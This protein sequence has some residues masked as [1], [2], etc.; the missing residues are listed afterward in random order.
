M[1]EN[2]E[3][4]E[5]SPDL[6]TSQL[7]KIANDNHVGVITLTDLEKGLLLEFLREKGRDELE[8]GQEMEHD[9]VRLVRRVTGA[10]SIFF[11]KEDT[12]TKKKSKE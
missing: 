7:L 10:V 4:I 2:T 1:A 6:T 3:K 5:L 11:E 12:G 8:L 9:K